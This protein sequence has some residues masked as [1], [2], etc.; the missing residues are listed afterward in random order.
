MAGINIPLEIFGIIIT[1]ILLLCCIVEKDIANKNN[2]C[3][4]A[5]LITN[6]LVLACDVVTWAFEGQPQFTA[7]LYAANFLVYSLGYVL[8]ALF[9]HYLAA[10]ITER[11][12]LSRWFIRVIDGLCAAAVL[13]VVLSLFNHMYFRFEGGFYF[14]GPIYWLSQLYPVLIMLADM[15]ITAYYKAA[16]GLHD[17]L[18]FLS[19]G[20]MPVLAML[21]QI[22]IYGITLLYLATTLSLLIIYS[23]IHVEQGKRLKEKEVELSQA[24]ISI[25]LSQIQPHFLYNVLSTIKYMC[26]TEPKTASVALEHFAYFLRGNMDAIKE[27]KLIRFSQEIEHVE[28]YLYLEKLRFGKKLNVE[29]DVRDSDFFLPTL[30]LQ[31]LVENA[32]R[33]GVTKRARGGTVWISARRENGAVI[34]EVRDDGVGFDVNEKKG[35]GRTHIGIENVRSRLA[36]QCGGQLLVE[37]V[38]NE[39]T[40]ATIILPLK[41]VQS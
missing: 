23:M 39:G 26:D 35:D 27:E 22:A 34:I 21:I 33:C 17:T 31:P 37:S 13:L 7:L 12:P 25:M 14:R 6:A 19:Y 24:S 40:D 1:G 2:G 8:T 16:L 4:I 41:E 5:M 15:I 10:S 20:F 38:P 9:T 28:N 36:Q 11:K 29:W 18:A 30:T 3:F 32:V